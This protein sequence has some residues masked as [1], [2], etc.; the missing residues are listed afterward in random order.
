MLGVVFDAAKGS[1]VRIADAT[2]VLANGVSQR[3]AASTGLFRFTLAPGAY[4]Y[5]ASAP[6]FAPLQ[7]TRTV[8]ADQDI[9]GSTGLR[10]VVAPTIRAAA[11][12][13][14]GSSLTMTI[15]ADAQSPVLLIFGGR[16]R[17]LS[18]GGF[19]VAIP[20]LASAVLVNAGV[21]TSNG[22]MSARLQTRTS[23]RG[24]RALVQPFA[25]RGRACKLGNAAG[26]AIN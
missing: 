1:S 16:P 25:L 2:V 19:G 22:L 9:W 10:P 13:R 6:G 26:F 18:L 8:Q 5:V 17:L 14:A 23:M 12:V 20:D 15:R 3:S 24:V 4:S 21:T 7:L 11:S